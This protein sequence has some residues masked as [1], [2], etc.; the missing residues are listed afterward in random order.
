MAAQDMTQIALVERNRRIKTIEGS[1]ASAGKTK[2]LKWLYGT[3]LTRGDA[4]KAKCCEC[5]G[6]YIDGRE[7]CLIDNCPLYPYM[8]YRKRGGK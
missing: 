2:L 7:D 1:P 6:Y 5:M 8:P 3:T 4:I